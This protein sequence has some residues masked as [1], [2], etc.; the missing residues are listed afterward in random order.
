MLY[1]TLYPHRENLIGTF[2]DSILS[3]KKLSLPTSKKDLGLWE[4]MSGELTM[5]GCGVYRLIGTT[6]SKT[7]ARG[8]H[9]KE[10]LND[11]LYGFNFDD[12]LI[13]GYKQTKVMK[14]KECVIQ[15]K[16]DDF[17]TFQDVP[18]LINLNFDT[19]RKWDYNFDRI[20]DVYGG[21]CDSKIISV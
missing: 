21:V 4:V 1:K 18:K 3:E 19:K 17:N 14:L 11:N 15:E 12:I 13:H 9:I 8:L 20:Q 7:R 6:E 5:I 16:L 10:S 2:T